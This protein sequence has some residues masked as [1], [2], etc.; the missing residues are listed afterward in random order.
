TS[1]ASEPPSSK[2]DARDEDA[3]NDNRDG[4]PS[5]VTSLSMGPRR[6]G[7]LPAFANQSTYDYSPSVMQDGPYRM[8][9]C[10]GLGGDHVCYAEADSLD[11][12]WHARG[13]VAAN[14]FNDVFGPTHSAATF[15]GTHTCDPSV[16]RVDGNYYMY[17]GGLTENV[18]QSWTRIGVAH[19]AD[20]V[21]W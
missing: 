21:T 20:G 16:I 1:D 2:G 9:W 17:Y 15:D 7:D 11:G 3:L 19:S 12:P 4:A 13:S 14:S 5:C 10:C 8:W 6:G 18:P